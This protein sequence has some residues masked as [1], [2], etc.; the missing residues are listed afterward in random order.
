VAIGAAQFGL[1][2]KGDPG[3]GLWEVQR[4]DLAIAAIRHDLVVGHEALMAGSDSS[5]SKYLLSIQYRHAGRYGIFIYQIG[6]QPIRDGRK[7]LSIA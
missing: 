2:D 5:W 1:G 7:Q 3:L 4:T 6:F